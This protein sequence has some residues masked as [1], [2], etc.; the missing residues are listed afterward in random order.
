MGGA[1]F[2]AGRAA[3]RGAAREDRISGRLDRRAPE[4]RRALHATISG[5]GRADETS[6]DRPAGGGVP[7]TPHFQSVHATV[8]APRRA[9][10][11]SGSAKHRQRGLLSF[12][13][14]FAKVLRRFGL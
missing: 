14:A 10:R 13:A 1:E 11:S 12:T 9:A 6:R 2:A 3:S 7:D 4:K 5:V 8:A